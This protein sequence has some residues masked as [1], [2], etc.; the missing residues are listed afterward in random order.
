MN[1]SFVALIIT[2]INDV[3]DCDSDF[4]ILTNGFYS[5]SV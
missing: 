2:F 4:S 1:N 3:Y 5:I